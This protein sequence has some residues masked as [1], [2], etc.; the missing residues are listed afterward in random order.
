MEHGGFDYEEC[1]IKM[2]ADFEAICFED[3][4][5]GHKLVD[6][7]SQFKLIKKPRKYTFS[8]SASRRNQ[9]VAN[10]FLVTQ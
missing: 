9:P 2:N 6:V 7:G 4:E 3:R 1:D 8:F 10:I 5:M